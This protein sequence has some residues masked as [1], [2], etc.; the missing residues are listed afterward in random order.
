MQVFKDRSKIIEGILEAADIVCTTMGPG[1]QKVVV[2]DQQISVHTDGVT[3][4]RQLVGWYDRTDPEK[5]AGVRMLLSAA[6]RRYNA[7]AMAL[8][9]LVRSCMAC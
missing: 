9:P 3:V 1:G 5:A 6:K 2:N 4:A 7:Q 8:R